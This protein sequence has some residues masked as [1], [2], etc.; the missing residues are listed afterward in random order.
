MA[1][2]GRRSLVAAAL[3]VSPLCA[4]AQAGGAPSEAPAAQAPVMADE[5]A[6]LANR[7][8]TVLGFISRAVNR[9]SE[10]QER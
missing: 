1:V 8:Q 9:G 4:S 10:R 6:L 2:V 7:K 3:F 5:A